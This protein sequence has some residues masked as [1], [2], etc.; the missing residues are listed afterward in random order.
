[1]N[2]LMLTNIYTPLVGGITRSIQQFSGE[3]RS[4]GHRVLVVAPEH[5]E[6]ASEPDVIRYPA[7]EKV[8]RDRYSFPLPVPGFLATALPE[9]FVP[10]V[11]H[12][13]HPFLLGNVAR[14]QAHY[15]GIPLVYTHHTNY[16]ENIAA[17]ASVPD[18]LTDLFEQTI[19]RYCNACEA[20]IAPSH[21]LAAAL[22]SRG[23][24]QPIEIIPTG[25][26]TG[27]FQNGDGPAFRARRGIP[28]EAFVVGTLGRLEPEKNITFLAE[29]VALFLSKMPEAH[30]LVVGHGHLAEQIDTVFEDLGAL[31][32]LHRTGTLEG[33]DVVDAYHAMNV[34]AFASKT[35]TQGMVLTEAFASGVPVVALPAMG[36]DDCL[37]DG[38]NGYSVPEE[39]PEAFAATLERLA[40]ADLSAKQRLRDGALATAGRFGIAECTSRLE[41]LYQSLPPPHSTWTTAREVFARLEQELQS[42]SDWFDETNRSFE[43]LLGT[44]SRK[45]R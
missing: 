1:M 34:F 30:F 23:V 3:L 44:S 6:A 26:E 12:S 35:E 24:T 21:G 28:E 20:I 18:I 37:M 39:S 5:E 13:H 36:V 25:L 45:D 33:Q 31:D 27:R 15:R 41:R 14:R 8:F 32:R 29:S 38:E 42:W 16:R 11:V 10:D 9:D 22:R 7:L 19:I 43:D 2:I 4:R 40:T 17:E